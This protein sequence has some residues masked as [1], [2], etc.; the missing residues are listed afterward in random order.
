M[1]R[2]FGKVE[3]ESKVRD[4]AVR[5]CVGHAVHVCI[6][7]RALRLPGSVRAGSVFFRVAVGATDQEENRADG[8][9]TFTT[10]GRLDGR[11]VG[12]FQFRAHGRCFM[13]RGERQE[14]G[15]GNRSEM[16]PVGPR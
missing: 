13:W 15:M 9:W 4:D 16:L 12:G 7:A 5:V 8:L 2:E 11:S 10:V 3:E 14:A 6:D 1:L